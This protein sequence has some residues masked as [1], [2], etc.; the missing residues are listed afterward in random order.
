[1]NDLENKTWKPVVLIHNI[2]KH[3]LQLPYA[4]KQHSHLWTLEL[5]FIVE[6]LINYSNKF[7]SY[8]DLIFSSNPIKLCSQEKR[9]K[10]R[11]LLYGYKIPP[12]ATLLTTVNFNT[13]LLTEKKIEVV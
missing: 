5:S 4:K 1:M 12:C 6:Y 11:Y 8:G 9:V 2:K 3:I 10:Y 7:K 13:K